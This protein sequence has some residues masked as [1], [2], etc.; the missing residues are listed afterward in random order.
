MICVVRRHFNN[1]SATIDY[2]CDNLLVF[3]SEKA[4]GRIKNT[5]ARLD[6]VESPGKK[7]AL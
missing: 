3:L 2:F 1:I 6:K 4:A 7:P 5:S